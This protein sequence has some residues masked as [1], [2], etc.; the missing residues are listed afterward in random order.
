MFKPLSAPAAVQKH[1]LFFS[2][3]SISLLGLCLDFS[4][5]RVLSYYG[6]KTYQIL[7]KSGGGHSGSCSC[8]WNCISNNSNETSGQGSFWPQRDGSSYFYLWEVTICSLQNRQSSTNPSLSFRCFSYSLG[9]CEE[10]KHEYKAKSLL[11]KGFILEPRWWL[12]AWA[13]GRSG[14]PF[15]R[16]VVTPYKVEGISAEAVNNKSSCCLIPRI[17]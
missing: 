10:M 7:L 6:Y 8:C 9:N 3:L 2:P 13:K 15:I 1:G 16:S 11:S 14:P 17:K 12:S 4:L 5:S